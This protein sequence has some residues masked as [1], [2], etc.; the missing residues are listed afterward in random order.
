MNEITQK[1]MEPFPQELIRTRPG[2]GGQLLRYLEGSTV[3]RRLIA[4][5]DNQFDFR[6]L[7]INQTGDVVVAK[8]ELEVPGLGKRQHI[9]CARVNGSE[10]AYKSCVTDSLKKVLTLFGTGLDLYSSDDVNEESSPYQD[11]R[12]PRNGNRT[13]NT[14]GTPNPRPAFRPI[15]QSA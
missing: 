5:T 7:D 14:Q 13:E 9:G 4:A 12:Q 8:C 1:L 2:K 15:R 10:D 6:V 3:L 11:N